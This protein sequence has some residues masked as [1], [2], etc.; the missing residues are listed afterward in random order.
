MTSNSNKKIQKTQNYT[1]TF[2]LARNSKDKLH[3]K[4]LIQ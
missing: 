3:V 1:L 2:D 4:K